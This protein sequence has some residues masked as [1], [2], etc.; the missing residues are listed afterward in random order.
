M[1]LK[2]PCKTPAANALRSG[3]NFGYD[4]NQL[5]TCN[6]FAALVCIKD[7][8]QT[9]FDRIVY[10]PLHCYRRLTGR[11]NGRFVGTATVRSLHTLARLANVRKYFPVR[12]QQKLILGRT[13]E[14]GEASGNGSVLGLDKTIFLRFQLGKNK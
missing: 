5:I 14:R 10:A 8:C 1:C 13:N 3:I 7:V 9:N 11:K 12:I 6:D 2:L 4:I